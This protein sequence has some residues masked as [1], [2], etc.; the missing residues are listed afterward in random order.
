MRP[1]RGQGDSMTDDE[2]AKALDGKLGTVMLNGLFQEL[3]ETHRNHR[4]PHGYDNLRKLFRAL[5]KPLETPDET[6]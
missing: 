5:G 3:V 1:V 6:D 2:I 4:S